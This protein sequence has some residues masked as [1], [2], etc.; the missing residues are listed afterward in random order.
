MIVRSK[1]KEVTLILGSEAY[2]F[3]D[4]LCDIPSDLLNRLDPLNYEV[5][6]GAVGGAEQSHLNSVMI[7]PSTLTKPGISIVMLTHNAVHYTEMAIT[8]I[9]KFTTCPY[10]LIVIDNASTDRTQDWLLKQQLD[11]LIINKQNLGVAKG[12]NQGIKKATYDVVCFLDNDTEVMENWFAPI[13]DGL[14]GDVVMV[15]KRGVRVLTLNP[16]QF[17]PPEHIGGKNYVDVGVGFCMAIRRPVFEMLGEFYDRFPYPKFWHEDLEFGLRLRAAGY[18]ILMA[19]IPIKHYEHKSI[20]EKVT[21]QESK[22]KV[23]GFDENARHISSLYTDRNVL[24]IYRNWMGYEAS[25]SYDRYYRGIIPELRQ[26]GFV[27]IRKPSIITGNKSFDLCKGFEMLYA[28]KRIV[29]LHQENDRCPDSWKKELEAVDYIFPA[30]EHVRKV[31]KDEEYA[32]KILSCSIGGIED[33]V[34]NISVKPA[35]YFPSVFKF[36]MVSATQPRKNTINLIKWYTEAF[37]KSHNTLLIIKDG[38]YG[39]S[40]ATYKYIQ[41]RQKDPNCARIEYIFKQMTSEE[42]AALYRAVAINGAYIHPHRAEALGLPILEAVACGCRVGTTDWGGPR[43]TTRTLKTVDHF[44][45]EMQPSSFH[46]WIGEPFYVKGENPM[47]AEPLE[48]DVKHFMYKVF[49][50]AYD[51]AAAKESSEQ[52]LTKYSYKNVSLNV[53]NVLHEIHDGRDA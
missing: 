20:G 50:H 6:G 16:L 33:T 1:H 2:N 47:W 29:I 53:S 41:E 32:H 43:Y 49:N 26:Q 40:G 51:Q 14:K 35:N 46:N 52:I 5:I 48:K 24:T 36:L 25:S 30:S 11:C 18:K 17:A 37:N 42:L 8:S 12:R 21:D 23:K 22:E 39:Q 19:D 31:C 10:E 15:T 38:D 34:Y 44:D 13:L 28:G 3:V 7:E 27:S 9:K 4:Y 45:F